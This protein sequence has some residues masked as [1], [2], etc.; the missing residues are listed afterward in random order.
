MINVSVPAANENAVVVFLFVV[1]VF[2][3]QRTRRT[4][5]VNCLLFSGLFKNLFL[6]HKLSLLSGVN[7]LENIWPLFQSAWILVA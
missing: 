2:F 7:V 4:A 6:E 5:T 1:V 3:P